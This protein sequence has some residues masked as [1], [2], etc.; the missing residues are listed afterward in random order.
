MFET[1]MIQFD[2]DSEEGKTGG[3]GYER[4]SGVKRVDDE[5]LIRLAA[6]S[7]SENKRRKELEEK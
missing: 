1:Q 4:R 3:S 6:R 5:H 7:A 2:A